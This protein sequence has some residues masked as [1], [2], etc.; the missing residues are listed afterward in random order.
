MFPRRSQLRSA[1]LN[2]LLLL[3]GIGAAL[4]LSE[5]LLRFFNPFQTRINGARIVLRTNKTIRI[6]NHFIERLDPVI[7]VT[8]NSLGFRGAEPPVDFGRYLTIITVGGSTTYSWMLSDEKT[9]PAEL[10]NHLGNSFQWVWINNAGL[11]GHSTFAHIVLMKEIVSKLRPRVVLFLVGEND[12]ALAK[13]R[14]SEWDLENVKGRI[15]F[16]SARGFLKSVSA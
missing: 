9:W 15:I 11:I 2:A 13:G 4:I 10:G 5:A 7:T 16:T 8:T 12:L 6:K 3:L 1:A 14:L